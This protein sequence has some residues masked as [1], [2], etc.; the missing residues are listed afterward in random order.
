MFNL[1]ALKDIDVSIYMV[2]HFFASFIN[3]GRRYLGWILR[4]GGWM[5]G[6]V[7]VGRTS[8]RGFGNISTDTISLLRGCMSRLSDCAD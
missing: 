4:A 8:V 3:E 6:F 7:A 2:E 5:V 1:I